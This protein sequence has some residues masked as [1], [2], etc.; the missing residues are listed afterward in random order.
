MGGADH[1]GQPI[2]K[3]ALRFLVLALVLI[4]GILG[5]VV[6]VQ[7]GQARI[8]AETK[9]N[10][11]AQ[12]SA[13]QA[14]AQAD[15]PLTPASPPPAVQATA[16]SEPPRSDANAPLGQSSSPADAAKPPEQAP[17]ESS[18]PA[19]PAFQVVARPA[20]VAAGVVETTRGRVT[21]KDIAPLDPEETCGQG[22]SAWP[23]GQLAATQFR[24]FLRGRS[25]NCEIAD[26]DWQG[27]VSARCTLGKEDV[28]AWLVEHGWARAQPGSPYEEA[29]REAKAGKRGIFAPDPRRP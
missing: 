10:T 3:F 6:L 14:A 11:S 20:I 7:M 15:A 28:G 21:M 19:A 12:S 23:C 18:V 1:L 25:L 16:V 5:A 8:A 17:A 2:G 9:A 24:R 26:P 22:S 29:G 27:D 4:A 13:P